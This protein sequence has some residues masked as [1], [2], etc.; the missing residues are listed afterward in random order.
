MRLFGKPP[1]SQNTLPALSKINLILS[2][3]VPGYCPP[4]S[5]VLAPA[6]V[7]DC[8]IDI[9]LLILINPNHWHIA[10]DK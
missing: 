9:Y 7:Y 8:D 2:T 4:L 3:F 6:G 1:V 5:D 10:T